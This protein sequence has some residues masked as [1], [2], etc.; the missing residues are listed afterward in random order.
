MNYPNEKYQ[1]IRHAIICY[2]TMRIKRGECPPLSIEEY[3]TFAK[4]C[5]Y[6]FCEKRYNFNPEEN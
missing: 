2:Y 5:Y 4:E 3:L 1:F 6:D